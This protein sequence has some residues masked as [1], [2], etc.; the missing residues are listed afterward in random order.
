MM[1][2][3]VLIDKVVLRV[4]VMGKLNNF[5]LYSDTVYLYYTEPINLPKFYVVMIN[6]EVPRAITRHTLRITV[7]TKLSAKLSTWQAG[8]TTL[9]DL[10]SRAND[11][12]SAN[13]TSV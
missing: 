7:T 5:K 12:F 3:N 4:P 8:R 6:Y 11:I 2:W 1:S 10:V 9:V 13:V